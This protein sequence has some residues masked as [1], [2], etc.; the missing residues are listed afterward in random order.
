MR[1]IIGTR[2]SPVEIF[3]AHLL[4]QVLFQTRLVS[5]FSKAIGAFQGSIVAAMC[6]LHMV[7]QKSLLCKILAAG[8]T[9]K[10]TFASM[11]A[12]MN[13]E[14]RFSRI[15]FGANGANEGFFTGMHADMFF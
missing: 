15:G 5:E 4:F 12:I 6:R 14:V 3:G 9:D 13:I 11:N 2:L 1:G 8:H 10:W 7:V